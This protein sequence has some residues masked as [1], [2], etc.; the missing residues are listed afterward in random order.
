MENLNNNQY[1]IDLIKNMNK[2]RIKKELIF[3]HHFLKVGLMIMSKFLFNFF[4][5]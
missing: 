4:F 3:I 5:I 2:M 1:S